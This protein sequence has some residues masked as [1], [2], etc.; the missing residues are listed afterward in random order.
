M[1]TINIPDSP[2]VAQ[3]VALGGV[4]YTFYFYYPSLT[5]EQGN[6]YHLDIYL[7]EELLISSIKLVEGISLLNR[8]ALDDFSHGDLYVVKVNTTDEDPG[9]NNVGF[10]KDYQLVYIGNDEV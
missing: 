2:N 5:T 10:N 1:L 8:H 4:N 9:R 6:Y 3:P 7:G